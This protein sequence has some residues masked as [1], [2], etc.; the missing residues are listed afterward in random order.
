V[1]EEAAI[2][3]YDVLQVSA[4]AD[5]EMVHRVYRL[6]AQRFHPDNRDTGNA[7]RFRQVHEAYTVL[8]DPERRAEYDAG[9]EHFRQKPVAGPEPLPVE[10]DFE[11]EQSARL[12]V[13]EILYAQRRLDP[14]HPG[15]YEQEMGEKLG[16]ATERLEFTAWYLREK[17]LARRA[18]DGSRLAI[19]AEGVEHLE[20]N[21]ERHAQRRL[22]AL[23]Q[24]A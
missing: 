17:G 24:S 8:G 3:Y 19:T 1:P 7:D 4:T 10:N 5:P 2:N 18:A 21:L 9:T 11:F 12:A 20:Q 16:I 14:N 22:Y 15:L 6:L 13:L 23:K